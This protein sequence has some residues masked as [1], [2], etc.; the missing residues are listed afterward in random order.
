MKYYR[1]QNS[2]QMCTKKWKSL[3]GKWW[4][5]VAKERLPGCRVC[6]STSEQTVIM[7][8]SSEMARDKLNVRRR[9]GKKP[10]YET[11]ACIHKA[12]NLLQMCPQAKCKMAERFGKSNKDGKGRR[13]VGIDSDLSQTSNLKGLK[14]KQLYF[15][16]VGEDGSRYQGK[17]WCGVVG[18]YFETNYNFKI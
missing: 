8:A 6:Y 15:K 12:S 9:R 13:V 2:V 10:V 14:T 18:L 11:I 7:F 16:S 17:R 4:L 3:P 1:V 5:I